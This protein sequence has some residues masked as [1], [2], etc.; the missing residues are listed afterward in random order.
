MVYRGVCDGRIDYLEVL[1]ESPAANAVSKFLYS[2][3]ELPLLHF[4]N[5]NKGRTIVS[6]MSLSP[7]PKGIRGH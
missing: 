3:T 6:V 5:G 4:L 2:F 7:S 1:S